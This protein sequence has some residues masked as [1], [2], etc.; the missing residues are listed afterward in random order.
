MLAFASS[1][2]PA[3]N[4]LME[5]VSAGN[6]Y[7]RAVGVVASDTVLL[8][9]EGGKTPTDWSA[10]GRYLSY[11]MRGDIWALPYRPDGNGEPIRVTNTPVFE[12]SE[13]RF[14]P[15]GRWVAY[16]S[17]ESANGQDVYL[18]SFP[19]PAVRRQ[20]STA[21]GAVPRWRADGA[22]LFYLAPDYMVMAVPVRQSG[23]DVEIGAPVPLFRAPSF[24]ELRRFSVARDGRFLMHVPVTDR[25]RPPITVVV[26]W[27]AALKNQRTRSAP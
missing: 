17:T 6:L 8:K 7:A 4:S 16:Q 21:G 3:E 18:Q 10:D 20:L 27:A 13:A 1:R 15:D 22:E 5:N 19:A 24:Q 26:N 14:S 2:E 11:T 9:S 25:V 23:N 12:E